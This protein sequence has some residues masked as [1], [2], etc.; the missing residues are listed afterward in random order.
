M[1][2]CSTA[3][4]RCWPKPNP[5]TTPTRP[6]PSPPK[7]T[8]LMAK[9]GIEQAMLAAAGQHNDPI[10]VVRIDLTN[11]YSYEKSRLLGVIAT[12]LHC[13]CVSYAIGR[14]VKWCEVSGYESDRERVEL[15]FT[16]LLLQAVG[17]ITYLPG[18]VVFRRSWW[19]GF[20]HAV[21]KRLQQIETRA[22]QQ[23]DQTR[24]GT[25][26]ELVLADRRTQVDRWYEQYYGE[27]D[28]GKSKTTIDPRA[29]AHGVAAGRRADLGQTRLDKR[30]AALR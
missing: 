25:G 13:R 3:C 16:S 2:S 17:Q 6:K 10:D 29:W 27:L 12:V 4:A 5:P 15:L 14:T 28:A 26:A 9:Y 20:A 21:G 24:S 30:R 19:M 1:T 23:Y 8:E 22:A 7:A 18:D 11:P